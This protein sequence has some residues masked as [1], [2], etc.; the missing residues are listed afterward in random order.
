MT[1]WI[2]DWIGGWLMTGWIDSYTTLCH[3]LC[4][5][6]MKEQEE[7]C[8]PLNCSGHVSTLLGIVRTEERGQINFICP[9]GELGSFCLSSYYRF[10]LRNRTA[11]AKVG[12]D[13]EYNAMENHIFDCS[14]I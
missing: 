4:Y 6:L 12:F 1:G 10:P 3:H 9:L 13:Q 2:D 14:A 7:T 5:V 8:S 11:G